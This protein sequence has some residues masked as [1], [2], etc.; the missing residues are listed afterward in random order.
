[1]ST[2]HSTAQTQTS[3][4]IAALAHARFQESEIVL[5]EVEMKPS[6]VRNAKWKHHV[7]LRTG[8]LK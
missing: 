2:V 3:A 4:N 8:E 6:E 5:V 7:V 1:M